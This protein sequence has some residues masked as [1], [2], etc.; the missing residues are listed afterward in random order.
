MWHCFG[1]ANR[2]FLDDDLGD[3]LYGAYVTHSHPI[4]ETEYSFSGDNYGLF[5]WYKLPLLRDVDEKYIYEFNRSGKVIDDTSD[6]TGEMTF[7]NYN[8][9][10]NIEIAKEIGIGYRRW[11]NDKGTSK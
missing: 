7:E 6:I 9:W 11:K 5:E 3:K 2:V 10:N 8:H 4:E 1:I